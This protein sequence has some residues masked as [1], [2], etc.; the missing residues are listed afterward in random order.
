[1]NRREWFH[2]RIGK[3]IYRNDDGCDCEGCKRVYEEGLVID[4]DF[5]A[6]YLTDIEAEYNI[7]GTRLR[8]FDTLNEVKDYEKAIINY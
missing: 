5:H 3:R 8:Y 4:D 6:D 1:M 2:E 7:E